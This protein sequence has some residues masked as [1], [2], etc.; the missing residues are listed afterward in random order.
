MLENGLPPKCDYVVR[1]SAVNENID[2]ICQCAIKDNIEILR[3]EEFLAKVSRDRKLLAM[4]GS[5]GKTFVSGICV[6]IRTNRGITFDDVAGGFLKGNAISRSVNDKRSEW[7]V[8]HQNV[9]LL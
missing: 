1:S 8:F 4:I 9:P 2:R 6:E 5:H 3:R 7:K